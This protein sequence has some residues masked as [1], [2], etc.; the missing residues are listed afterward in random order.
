MASVRLAPLVLFVLATSIM[1]SVK[2]IEAADCSGACSV[3][4]KPPCR[5]RD[6]FC[7][8]MGIFVGVCIS[9]FGLSAAAKMIDEHPNLCKSDEECM[10]KGSGNFCAPYPNHYMNY[11]W[12]FN[13]GSDELKGFLAMARAISK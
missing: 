4:E 13:F 10:K 5:S 7:I 12:C 1:F 11:G 8:P 9:P 2:N 3:F 6:C